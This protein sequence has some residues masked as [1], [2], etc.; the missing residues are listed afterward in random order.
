VSNSKD[1]INETYFSK[2]CSVHV[3][4]LRNAHPDSGVRHSWLVGGAAWEIG[5]GRKCSS[6]LDLSVARSLPSLSTAVY[7][8][9]PSLPCFRAFSQGHGAVRRRRHWASRHL[10]TRADIVAR[11]STVPSARLHHHRCQSPP[12]SPS[13][14]HSVAILICCAPAAAFWAVRP[15]HLASER[16][17]RQFLAHLSALRS[18]PC[19][20]AAR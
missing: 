17:A 18:A 6:I 4:A 8:S 1:L 7:I 10:T 3:A 5:S 16:L 20:P 19:S 9:V 12:S 2:P 14:S 13:T 15:W 11:N